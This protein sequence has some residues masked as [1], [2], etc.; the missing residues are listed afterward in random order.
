MRINPSTTIVDLAFNLSGSLAG[1]PAALSQLPVGEKIGFATLPK[2]WEDVS[3]IGQTWTPSL[4]GVEIDIT[5]DVYNPTAVQKAPY[6]T[7]I[8]C[9]E[10]AASWGN[11]LLDVLE[12]GEYVAVTDIPMDVTYVDSV[13][14]INLNEP[15]IIKANRSASYSSF[16]NFVYVTPTSPNLVQ[17]I[18]FGSAPTVSSTPQF[19]LAF[20]TDR[21]IANVIRAQLNFAADGATAE[22]TPWFASSVF[23][24]N[25]NLEND[26][27]D[28]DV[29]VPTL[30]AVAQS[31]AERDIWKAPFDTGWAFER[32][33]FVKIRR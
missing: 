20:S 16:V 21:Y 19:N 5:L 27:F 3:D 7:D 1:I 11:A 17:Y 22:L 24:A 2:L 10:H 15:I 31:Q 25:P 9:I 12:S 13:R 28:A 23:P 26:W 33:I 14:V 8:G 4:E 32:N 6:T 29:K 18:D 30:Y